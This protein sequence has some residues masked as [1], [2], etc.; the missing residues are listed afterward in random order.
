MNMSVHLRV[1]LIV[2]LK[3]HLH[4]RLK[5][6]TLGCNWVTFEDAHDGP[7]VSA[8]E[9]TKLFKKGELEEAIYVA[10]EGAPKVSL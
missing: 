9:F 4:L 7:L 1:L 10:L 8:K 2:Y 5:G 6:S 3:T